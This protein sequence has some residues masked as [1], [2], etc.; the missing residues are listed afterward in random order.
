MREDSALS[1]LC[2]GELCI[3]TLKDGSEKE[4]RWNTEY[5]RFVD[6]SG[7]EPIVCSF[8]EIEEWRPASI[9]F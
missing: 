4:V 5:W 2:H 3:V 8:D 7:P 9:K 6:M 1:H